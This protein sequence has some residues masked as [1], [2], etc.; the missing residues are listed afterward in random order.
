MDQ[1]QL[2][3]ITNLLTST[4]PLGVRG[5]A[6]TGALAGL[7]HEVAM[8]AYRTLRDEHERP[9]SIATFH[10]VYRGAQAPART[11]MSARCDACEGTGWIEG[12]TEI[13]HG[14]PYST[15]RRCACTR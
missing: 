13:H 4:W 11:P 5:H 8:R 12:P 2:A 1:K 9:P 15:L 7:D 3:E 14:H 6:W 10:A